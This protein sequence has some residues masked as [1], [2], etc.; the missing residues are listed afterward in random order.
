MAVRGFLS[1]YFISTLLFTASYQFN[2]AKGGSFNLGF[3]SLGS[4]LSNPLPFD[5]VSG[6]N[7]LSHRRPVLGSHKCGGVSWGSLIT[8]VPNVWFSTF[9]GAVKLRLKFCGSVVT[10]CAVWSL[11]AL[12]ETSY[13]K[14]DS[15]SP[16]IRS[17]E[18]NLTFSGSSLMVENSN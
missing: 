3:E 10:F 4:S 11:G 9:S 18:E 7:M 8:S 15:R 5:T 13:A 14:S 1:C 2:R 17:N 16:D 6:S 12:L